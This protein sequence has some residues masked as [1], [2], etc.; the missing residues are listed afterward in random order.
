MTSSSASSHHIFFLESHARILKIARIRNSAEKH[1]GSV[2]DLE[3][4]G[5]A[6]IKRAISSL[7]TLS[8]LHVMR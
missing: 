2:V 5:N 6:S 1:Y 3:E 7:T 4:S 8:I